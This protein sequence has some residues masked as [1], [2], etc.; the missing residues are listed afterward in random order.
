MYESIGEAWADGVRNVLR[1]GQPVESVRSRLSKAS[2]FGAVDRPWIELIAQQIRV[3]ETRA[4][5]LTS[6]VI[7]LH[8]PYAIGLLAWTLAGRDDL[9]TLAYYNSSARDF[10]D[11]GR[12]LCGAFGARM[13]STKLDGNQLAA[14]LERLRSDPASRRTFVPIIEAEDNLQESLEYPC[15]A[16]VQLFLRGDELH[17]L[18]VMRAQQALTVMP[19]DLSLFRFVHRYAAA[20]LGARVGDYT[21]F[22]GTF[23]VYEAERSLAHQF[24][25]SERREIVLPDI[26]V[27]HAESFRDEFVDLEREIRTSTTLEQVAECRSRHLNFELSRVLRERLIEFALDRHSRPGG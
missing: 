20:L 16:G 12:T 22:C 25:A 19:Y 21:H 6:D 23:H 4:S 11:D 2:N 15:A 5:L 9:E 17:W 13:Q 26:P 27:G 3:R 8:L 7:P 24:L 18:T 1:D 10:S 14:V